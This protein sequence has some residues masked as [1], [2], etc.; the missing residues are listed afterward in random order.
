MELNSKKTGNAIIIYLQGRLD[1]HLSA[2]IEKE[3]NKLIGNTEG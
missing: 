3:I 2:D 1:V